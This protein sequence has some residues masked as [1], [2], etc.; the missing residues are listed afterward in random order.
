MGAVALLVGG[1]GFGM[2][3]CGCETR[4]R[5]EGALECLGLC[6]D[7]FAGYNGGVVVDA[8]DSVIAADVVA[9][10]VGLGRG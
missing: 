7:E 9:V 6:F 2:K 10:G 4:G 8:A 1:A 3:Y 5:E